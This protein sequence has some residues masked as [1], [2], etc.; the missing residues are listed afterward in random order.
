MTN[1]ADINRRIAELV[2]PDA[3][4]NPNMI[5]K[6]VEVMDFKEGA[7]GTTIIDVDYCNN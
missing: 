7:G 5:V 2:F 1:K 6:S 4:C 3:D